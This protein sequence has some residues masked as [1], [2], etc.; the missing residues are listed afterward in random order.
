MMWEAALE[1]RQITPELIVGLPYAVAEQDSPHFE[2][3]WQSA[4]QQQKA[5]LIALSEEHEARPFSRAFQLKH[6]IGPSSSIKASLD[7][8]VKKGILFRTK[9]GR[10]QFSD[11]FMKYWIFKLMQRDKQLT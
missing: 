2:L 10:Y 5:L 4:S 8:L 7:S 6:G 11:T 3:M 1:S 9:E